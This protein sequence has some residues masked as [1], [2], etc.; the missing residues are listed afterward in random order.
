[1]DPV[2]PSQ[3]LLAIPQNGIASLKPTSAEPTGRRIRVLHIVADLRTGG[4]EMM[5]FR[6]INN[7]DD[8]KF[9]H[10]ILSMRSRGDLDLI[11]PQTSLKTHTLGINGWLD[12]VIKL[13]SFRRVIRIYQPD[14]IH[15]WLYHANVI[16]GV[17]AYACSDAKIVWGLHSGWLASRH[18]K[19]LTRIM[20]QI[21]GW[22]SSW[23]PD[24][25]V[26]CAH[27]V[28]EFHA[29]LGYARDKLAI[30]PNGVALDRFFPD[31]FT[32][33]KLRGEWRISPSQ[34]LVGMV[35]R[36]DA[37]KDFCTFLD[38]AEIV[39]RHQPNTHFLLCG[40]GFDETNDAVSQELERRNLR[41]SF[42][43][44]GFRTDIP[45]VMAALDTLVLSSL[46]G[47]AFPL[48]IIEAMACGVPVVA[49]DIGDIQHAV[50]RWGKVVSPAAPQEFADAI[51]D[52]AALPLEQRRLVAH[53]ARE[54]VA[55][56]FPL[57]LTIDQHEAL[58]RDVLGLSGEPGTSSEPEP[59]DHARRAA[60]V[61]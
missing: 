40:P 45:R 54:R 19:R 11:L 22:L 29:G 31:E 43:L 30:I 46:F 37:Q 55:T 35:A 33:R 38:A 4:A 17:M 10:E 61:L 1:M 24:R 9:E 13:K 53:N 49:S 36:F 42:T 23:V 28:R 57:S 59:S 50:G 3:T 7:S 6:L 44:L 16:G 21:G 18:T 15:T 12:G 47:E 58:Y 8:T 34:L 25:V 2:R 52:Y 39:R 51:L 26:C 27:S 14:I 32:R 48:V 5:L 56:M 41:Q 60:E 20:R